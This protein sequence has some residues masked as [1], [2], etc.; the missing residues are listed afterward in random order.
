MF[1]ILL[2][3]VRHWKI[4]WFRKHVTHSG[5]PPIGVRLIDEV[6]G[7][8]NMWS[9]RGECWEVHRLHE[10]L[11]Y[12]GRY[13]AL[14]VLRWCAF[15][16]LNA[17]IFSSAE[18][19]LYSSPNDFSNMLWI[20]H[21]NIIKH[22]TLYFPTNPSRR[23]V[24]G[25]HLSWR[26]PVSYTCTVKYTLACKSVHRLWTFLHFV[27]LHSQFQVRYRDLMW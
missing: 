22:I 6:G 26:E 16:W 2:G 8:V 5:F 3:P 20:C 27:W 10:V 11:Q 14:C 19:H 17:S 4:I 21:W 7:Q 24:I 25:P 9:Q 15:R 18:R 13:T 23:K 1:T 12:G